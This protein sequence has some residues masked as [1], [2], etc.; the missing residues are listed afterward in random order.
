MGDLRTIC[1]TSTVVLSRPPQNARGDKQAADHYRKVIDFIRT[2]PDQYDDPEL[3][4]VFHR[5]AH[6][7]D[8]P[9]PQLIRSSDHVPTK[10]PSN[11]PHDP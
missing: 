8:P 2:D 4:A 9:A 10:P 1:L 7:L 5:L 11:S 6:Q 3:E